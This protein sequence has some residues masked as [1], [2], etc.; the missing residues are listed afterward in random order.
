M[1]I[2]Y[3]LYIIKNIFQATGSR[4]ATLSQAVSTLIGSAVIA[5]YYNWKVGLVVLSSVPL[6]LL[7]MYLESRINSGHFVSSGSLNKRGF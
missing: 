6:V 4:L 3:K 2:L 1:L 5:L 7:A